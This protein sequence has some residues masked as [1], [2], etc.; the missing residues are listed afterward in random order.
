M[1]SELF[2]LGEGDCRFGVQNVTVQ[3]GVEFFGCGRESK[4]RRESSVEGGPD[5][6]DIGE[7]H[8]S[9]VLG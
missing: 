8:D 2:I 6:G 4:R 5:G 3:F 7:G 1:G 9:V